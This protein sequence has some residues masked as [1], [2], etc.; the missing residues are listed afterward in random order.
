MDAA[1]QHTTLSRPLLA[2]ASLTLLAAALSLGGCSTASTGRE[3]YFASRA[4]TVMFGAGTGETRVSVGLD[5][6]FGNDVGLADASD[7]A[8]RALGDNR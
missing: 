5:S 3:A 8:P 1:A 4:D 2:A 7:S 6:P